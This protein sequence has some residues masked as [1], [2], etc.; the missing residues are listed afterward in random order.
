MNMDVNF[1]HKNFAAGMDN[2]C[3]LYSYCL[4]DKKKKGSTETTVTIKEIGCQ[5]TAIGGDDD[6][7]EYQKCIR[8]SADGK[9][10]AAASS[11][12][13]VKIMKVSLY[14]KFSLIY[15]PC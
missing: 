8:F 13:R 9:I 14:S 12:G 11:E 1:I 6:D 10:M 4:E 3:R 7:A 2:V 15:F 5:T